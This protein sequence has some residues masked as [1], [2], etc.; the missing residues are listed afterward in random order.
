MRPQ[1][2]GDDNA[3]HAAA[4]TTT[5]AVRGR[6]RRKTRRQMSA[7]YMAYNEAL[8]KAG[9]MVSGERLQAVDQPPSCAVRDGK[10]EVLDGPFADTKEQLGGYLHHRG[11]GPRRR[12][13]LGGALPRRQ[14]RHRRGAADLADALEHG[15]GGEQA[16]AAA[17]SGCPRRAMAGS[18]PF[19]RRARAMSPAPRTRWPTPL[20][21]PGRNGPRTGVPD[22]PEAWLL[23]VARRRP[24]DAA[25][26]AADRRGGPRALRLIARRTGGSRR[27]TRET[28]PTSGSA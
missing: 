25:P 19:S 1:T 12:D 7:P 5:N 8:T 17:R 14:P 22:N 24:I 28:F 9:A 13:Q 3:V 26:A 6:Q 4:S 16:R 15:R 21:R 20:P 18:S 11:A 2:T 23:T 10:T 27:W